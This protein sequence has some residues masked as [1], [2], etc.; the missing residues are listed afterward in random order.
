MM[1]KISTT[2]ST[3][4]APSSA[5]ISDAGIDPAFKEAMDSYEDFFDEYV[6]FMLK[7]KATEDV[8]P[9][10]DEYGSMMQQYA[11]TMAALQ[12]VDQDSLTKEEALYYSEVMLR[13]NQKILEAA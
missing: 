3:K 5:S 11:E 10:M 13:I 8:L 2:G 12:E 9:L 7:F 1:G 6:E 4:P